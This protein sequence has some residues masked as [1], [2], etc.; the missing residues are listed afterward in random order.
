[1]TRSKGLGALTS[2]RRGIAAESQRRATRI[3]CSDPDAGMWIDESIPALHRSACFFLVTAPMYK[4]HQLRIDIRYRG[5]SSPA[6]DEDGVPLQPRTDG[7]TYLDRG[8]VTVMAGVGPLAPEPQ[9]Y[10]VLYCVVLCGVCGSM[11]AYLVPWRGTATCGVS[12]PETDGSVTWM[13]SRVRLGRLLMTAASTWSY[14]A[15]ACCHH[16][17]IPCVHAVAH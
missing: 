2:G 8:C 3:D 1:M 17:T 16:Y 11:S 9:R 12:S 10:V 5:M 13:Q 14:H 4:D 15:G 6:V 7:S